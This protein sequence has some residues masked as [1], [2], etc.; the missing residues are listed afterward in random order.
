[1]KIE[2][3]KQSG[4]TELVSFSEWASPGLFRSKIAALQFYTQ[5]LI[6]LS[7][8]ILYIILLNMFVAF[9]NMK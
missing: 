5:K 4:I 1:M 3:I 7:K 9:R 8:S 6:I 2:A